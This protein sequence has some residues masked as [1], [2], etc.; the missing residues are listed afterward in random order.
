MA[1]IPFERYVL[2]TSLNQDEIL[3]RLFLNVQARQN[4]SLFKSRQGSLEY[5]GLLLPHE[6]NIQ[7]IISYRNSF[8]PQIKGR[9][10]P[11][12][13]GCKI[14]IT[15][16][17]SDF[18]SV[19]MCI[20]LGFLGLS[21]FGILIS[22]VLNRQFESA[23]LFLVGMFVFGYILATGCFKLESKTSK[24]FMEQLFDAKQD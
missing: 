11:Q 5:E 17:L 16:R 14:N 13:N 20:W 1:F 21:F 12:N 10:V 8:L 4:F 6:F 18:V 3:E 15:M 24:K 23:A 7:R 22:D 2:S 19:F 9:I